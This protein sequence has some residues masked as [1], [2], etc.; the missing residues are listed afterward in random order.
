M[1]IAPIR[2]RRDHKRTLREIEGLMTAKR[3]TPEGSRLDVLVPN[4][5]P[6]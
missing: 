5:K 2:T 3:N 6:D 1:D 4:P